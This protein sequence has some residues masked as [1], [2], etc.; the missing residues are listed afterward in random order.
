LNMC[1]K[2]GESGLNFAPLLPTQYPNTRRPGA[3][4]INSKL[5]AQIINEFFNEMIAECSGSD[6]G[7]DAVLDDFVVDNALRPFTEY[8]ITQLKN[9]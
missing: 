9:D 5:K 6:N 1:R 7:G 3:N 2:L 4:M 8:Y